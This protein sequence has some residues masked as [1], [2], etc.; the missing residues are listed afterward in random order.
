[1]MGRPA[2]TDKVLDITFLFESSFINF[3]NKVFMITVFEFPLSK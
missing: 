3:K 2:F 1:M